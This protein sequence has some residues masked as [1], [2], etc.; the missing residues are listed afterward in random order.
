[1]LQQDLAHGGMSQEKLGEKYGVSQQAVSDFAARHA[2]TIQQIRDDAADEFAGLAIAKKAARLEVYRELLDACMQPVPKVAG[3]DAKYVR[4]ED[5]Q[6]VYEID[7]GVASKILRQ[8]AEELGHLPN[9]VTLSGDVGVTT[10][11][12]VNGVAPEG[13]K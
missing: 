13:L 7:A 3:K 11:Y 2:A 5:G 9:R 10:N 1:M 12:T 8:V 6:I 4:D